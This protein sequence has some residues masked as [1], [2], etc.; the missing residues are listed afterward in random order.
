MLFARVGIQHC[1]R[2]D[3]RVKGQ[4]PQQVAHEIL[5]QAKAMSGTTR[6]ILLSPLLVNRKGEHRELLADA[7]RA[8][9]VRLRIDGEVVRTEDVE[10]LDKRRK[11]NVDAVIDRVTVSAK[12]M[13]RLTESVENA[14][15]QGKGTMVV[16]FEGGNE[17]IF[18]ENLACTACKIS[19]PELTPQGFSFNSPQGMCDDCNGMGHRVAIDPRLVIPDHSLSIDAGAIAPWGPDVSKKVR[20]EHGFRG[21]ILKHL[22]A[23]FK[24][25]WKK[26]PKKMRDEIL[27][28]TG[29]DKKYRVVWKGKSGKGQFQVG[30]EGLL[31]RLM[32]RFRNTKSDRAKRWYAQYL[33][34][35]DCTTC[36]GARLR[37]ES[38]AVRIGGR[39]IVDVSAMTVAEAQAFF[40]K[41]KL[42]GAAARIA[43]EVL[44]E[45]RSRLNF[46]L[47]VGLGYLSLDRTGPYAFRW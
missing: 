23:D 9:Y 19:F 33:G 25:P 2:C 4:S 15:R 45:L 8:G 43:A 14:L 38:A 46:L 34:D 1:P 11:H 37:P 10:A 21:Q 13:A 26:L 16:A 39:S 7:R 35:A 40:E 12:S 3:K 6:A 24:R 22:K 42:N 5:A 29:P 27:Y 31:P 44:K 28:G 41:L 30:W 36:R 32:R 17:V 20:W 18:S 47:A